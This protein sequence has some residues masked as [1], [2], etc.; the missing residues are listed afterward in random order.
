LARPAVVG[1]DSTICKL[2]PCHYG[3]VISGFAVVFCYSALRYIV[4][5]AGAVLGWVGLDS[6]DERLIVETKSGNGGD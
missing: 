3:V 4:Q 2:R 6:G 1:L 5:V